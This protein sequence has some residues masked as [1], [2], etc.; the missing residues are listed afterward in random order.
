MAASIITIA[1]EKGGCGK[2]V[3]A[4]NFADLM[5]DEGKKTLCV[6]TDPQGNLTFALTGARITD[7]T[8]VGHG[9]YDMYNAFQMKPVKEFISETNL[10]NVDIIPANSSTPRIANRLKDLLADSQNLEDGNP[11]KLNGETEFLRY[12]LDQVREEYDYI[13]IDTQPSRDNIMV[14]SALLAADYV[15]IP[16]VCD[17]FAMDSA[18]RTFTLCNELRNTGNTRIKGIGV[19]L[20]MV[21][22]SAA[23]DRVRENCKAVLGA[24]LFDTEIRYGKSVKTSVLDGVPVVESARTQPPAKSYI[25]AYKEL[26][27]RLE[28]L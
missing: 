24:T 14:T 26:K 11:A 3:S 20:T 21:E 28:V 2:T 10:E 8:Y 16:M 12:F 22:K 1:I 4:T 13:V 7:R 15:L 25:A 27:K 6:D 17:A 9:L 5:G 18:F 23:A 19:M